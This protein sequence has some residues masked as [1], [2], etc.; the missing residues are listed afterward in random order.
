MDFLFDKTLTLTNDISTRGLSIRNI[1]I[2]D[3]PSLVESC[4]VARGISNHD[5]LLV[6][7]L[8]TA[9]LSHLFQ[10]TILR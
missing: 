8:V 6:I 9:S 7:S 1:S 10:R 5:T 3:I 4:D 2:T